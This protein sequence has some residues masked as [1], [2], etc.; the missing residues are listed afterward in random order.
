MLNEPASTAVN[1][2]RILLVEDDEEI[3]SVSKYLT[4][5]GF[6]VKLAGSGKAMDRILASQQIDLVVL[7]INLPGLF[8]SLRIQRS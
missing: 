1:R 5:N 2:R 4:D 7:D 3:K 8:S 6:D